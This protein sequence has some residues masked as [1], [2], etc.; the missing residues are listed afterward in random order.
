M[1]IA[2]TGMS[3]FV[4]SH[5]KRF[6]E[7]EGHRVTGIPHRMLSE[8]SEKELREALAGSDAVI[9]L[10]GASINGRWSKRKKQEI[11]ESRIRST[12]ILVAA[13]NG[14]ERAPEVFI[15]T[16]AIGY[17]AYDGIHTEESKATQDGFLSEVC[18]RWEAEASRVRKEVR[19]VILRFGLILGDNGGVFPHI[20]KPARMGVHFI[21]GNGRQPFSWI[22]L[23]DLVAVFDLVLKD[24]NLKGVINC[25]APDTI[26]WHDMVVELRAHYPGFA[27]VH[28]PEWMLRIFLLDGATLLT[29][30]QQVVPMRLIENRF[31]FKYPELRE[32]ASEI[33][34]SQEIGKKKH[35]SK[36]F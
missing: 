6:L 2:I 20:L 18:R 35:K 33:I 22:H 19:L 1:K 36:R 23:V 8:N 32:A 28:L 11:L 30:G 25:V 15:S 5:L 29:R 17:Y 4:G 3:G 26:T 21:F 12:R 9:N 7:G 27:V 34:A 13:I 10:A 31:D 16:S 24:K 14:L